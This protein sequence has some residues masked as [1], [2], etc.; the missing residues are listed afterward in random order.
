[1]DVVVLD[2]GQKSALAVVRA[3]RQMG[4]RVVVGASSHTA[5]ALHSRYVHATFVY[6]DP[7]HD[8]DAFVHALREQVSGAAVSPVV[9]TFSEATSVTLE[10][11][12]GELESLITYPWHAPEQFAYVTDK[13]RTNA[14]AERC[15]VPT[16]PTYHWHTEA[17]LQDALPSVSW[18][19][20][21]KPRQSV[22]RNERS[23]LFGSASFVHS[24]EAL[25]SA[26][27]T[28][29]AVTGASPLVQ[30][31]ITGAEYGVEL[32]AQAGKIRALLVHK[33]L[34]SLS[35]TGGASVLK[36]TV[37]GGDR[38]ETLVS[39]AHTLVRELA[40]TG[41]CMVEF[42]DD[43]ATREVCLMEINGRWWGSL[44]LATRADVDMPG[45]YYELMRGTLPSGSVVINSTEVRSNYFL[46]DVRHLLRVLFARDRMRA[47][48]FPGR[49]QALGSF[50]WTQLTVPYDVWSWYDPLPSLWQYGAIIKK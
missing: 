18:P 34:R 39:Y 15:S 9:Y 49:L 46:G 47:Q 14:L 28:A 48:L 11:F 16:I 17:E 5:M 29:R 38:Y 13:L 43:D 22:T 24:E 23:L 35:P 12:R 30:P 33:R 41:P 4:L 42:K 40:W 3:L 2:G 10:Q 50:L 26:W 44:P 36:E 27:H 6:P 1:M 21:I 45:I 20:V 25:M 7:T 31:M 32:V 8:Q 19:L 37:V